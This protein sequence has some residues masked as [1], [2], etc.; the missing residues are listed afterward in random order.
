MITGRFGHTPAGL[1]HCPVHGVPGQG[2]CVVSEEVV[3]KTVV[4]WAT[5]LQ[6]DGYNPVITAENSVR[7]VRLGALMLAEFGVAA[8]PEPEDDDG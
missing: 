2:V 4:R 3:A 7:L 6:L 8:D 5:Q 1:C